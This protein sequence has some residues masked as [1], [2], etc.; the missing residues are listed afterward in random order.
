MIIRRNPKAI[1]FLLPILSIS[2]PPIKEN[3]IPVAPIIANNTPISS[4]DNKRGGRERKSEM[5]G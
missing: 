5:K 1:V 4:F 3:T 2:M